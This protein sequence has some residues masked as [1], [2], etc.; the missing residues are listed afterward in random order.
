MPGGG[1][2]QGMPPVMASDG[3]PGAWAF[4]RCNPGYREG[5]SGAVARPEFE[6]AP[7][8][9][10]I[11]SQAD[12]KALAWG[13]LGWEDPHERGDKPASPFW[14]EAPMLGGEWATGPP[15]LR[16][17]LARSGAR[18]EG[19]RL[20]D[21]TLILEIENGLQAAQVRIEP[22]PDAGMAA[23]RTSVFVTARR[24]EEAGRACAG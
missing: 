12:R 18:V 15:P 9:V 19:L 16:K 1:L 10:G 13:V 3:G 2:G 6:A 24:R 14:A 5:R 20:A 4:L 7:F 17:P 22:G 23:M 21:G 11:Q 8:P